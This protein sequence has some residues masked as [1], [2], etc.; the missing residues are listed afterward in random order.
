MFEKIFINL[1]EIGKDYIDI[2]KFKL[3]FRKLG[4]RKDDPRVYKI[5]DRLAELHADRISKAELKTIIDGH[6][7]FTFRTLCEDFIIPDF[8]GF[9]YQIGKLY[10]RC[11]VGIIKQAELVKVKSTLT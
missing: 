6:I 11:T 8:G 4:I 1:K 5:F 7:D 10:M 2:R 3:R 9:S